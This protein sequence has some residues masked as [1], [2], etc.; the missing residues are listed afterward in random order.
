MTARGRASKDLLRREH[1][2]AAGGHFAVL[3]QGFP[4]LVRLSPEVVH[5]DDSRAGL[6][7]SGLVTINPPWQFAEDLQRI[8]PALLPV[9][10]P[11]GG[12]RTRVVLLA[13]E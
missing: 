9:L 6:N 13:G 3:T 1:A 10:A 8:L 2:E 4:Q 12:G 11:D 7:G 5:P